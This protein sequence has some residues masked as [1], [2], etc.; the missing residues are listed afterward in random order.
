MRRHLCL[1]EED[2]ATVARSKRAACVTECSV[3]SPGETWNN[4]RGRTGDGRFGR[5]HRLD[6]A[7]RWSYTPPPDAESPAAAVLG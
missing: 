3:V 5:A 7:F 6:Q 4:K 2:I 1:V